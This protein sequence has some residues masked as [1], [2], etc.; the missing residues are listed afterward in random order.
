MSH[1]RQGRRCRCVDIEVA[2]WPAATESETKHE[3][4]HRNLS[5]NSKIIDRVML[6]LTNLHYHVRKIW[7]LNQHVKLI[8]IQIII[9]ARLTCT[10]FWT[11]TQGQSDELY[12]G[13]Y[14]NQRKRLIPGEQLRCSLIF[15]QMQDTFELLN[16]L[17][18]AAIV[19]RNPPRSSRS[20]FIPFS[21][22]SV[23][24]P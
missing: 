3:H 2:E 18:P 22:L 16:P 21:S 10:V 13:C 12:H 14:G 9:N 19:A 23:L 24:L 11:T 15:L 5:R 7:K 1:K 6:R 20:S 8:T 4:N 17:H